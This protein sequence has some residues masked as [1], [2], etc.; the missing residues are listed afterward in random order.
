MRDNDTGTLT[1]RFAW[2]KTQLFALAMIEPKSSDL[3]FPMLAT[4]H[5]FKQPSQNLRPAFKRFDFPKINRQITASKWA[6][7]DTAPKPHDC[8]ATFATFAY[9]LCSKEMTVSSLMNHSVRE[10]DDCAAEQTVHYVGILPGAGG[11]IDQTAKEMQDISDA[12]TSMARNVRKSK[13]TVVK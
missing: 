3:I 4:G 5:K 6:D 9:A 7:V 10:S 11:T 1:K 12:I 8:R 13:L 2:T